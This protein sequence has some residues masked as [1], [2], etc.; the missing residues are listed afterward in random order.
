MDRKW[1]IEGLKDRGIEGSRERARWRAH[2]PLTRHK[3]PTRHFFLFYDF[4]QS[5]SDLR[6]LLGGCE[7]KP[8]CFSRI[9]RWF[10][11]EGHQVKP[12]IPQQQQQQQQHHHHHQQQR[13]SLIFH[14]SF[15]SRFKLG[16]PLPPLPVPIN[17]PTQDF[18]YHLKILKSALENLKIKFALNKQLDFITEA[19]KK[20]RF[21][22]KCNRCCHLSGR[23]RRRKMNQIQVEMQP[24]LPSV[25]PP[26]QPQIESNH[27]W[28]EHSTGDGAQ[29]R[30]FH[31]STDTE[32]NIYLN[33]KIRNFF[34]RKIITQSTT[35]TKKN[36]FFFVSIGRKEGRKEEEE[37]KKTRWN[38]INVMK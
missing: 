38:K 19:D 13:Q 34:N 35:T 25:R 33:N 30:P 3:A 5:I 24:V 29:G 14:S 1:R 26:P 17:Y 23:R 11:P 37:G 27:R 18:N 12:P 32:F 8:R 28:K 4:I 31:P 7:S 16:A 36:P 21:K 20:I 10:R 6:L 22:W 9:Q 2:R 15:P